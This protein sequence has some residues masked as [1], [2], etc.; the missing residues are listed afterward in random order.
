MTTGLGGASSSGLTLS[1]KNTGATDIGMGE[2]CALNVVANPDEISGGEIY[3]PV[4]KGAG[5][6]VKYC[7]IATSQIKAGM[8]GTIVVIGTTLVKTDG[9]VAA[10]DAIRPKSGAEHTVE[11]WATSGQKFGIALEDDRVLYPA[12]DY[13]GAGSAIFAFC[14]VFFPGDGGFGTTT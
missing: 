3:I 9:T 7:G 14:L 11:N 10:G 4:Q 1:V 12:P 8:T 6:A 2:V 5:G 13:G